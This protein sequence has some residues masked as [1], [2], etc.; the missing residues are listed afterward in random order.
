MLSRPQWIHIC[1]FP[2]VSGKHCFLE[3]IHHLWTLYIDQLWVS[4]LIFIYCW[5]VLCW[6]MRDS[7]LCRYS[8]KSSRVV[9]M[10]CLFSKLI[11]VGSPL[12]PMTYIDIGSWPYWQF[13]TWVSFHGVDLKSNQNVVGHSHN[14]S[15]LHQWAYLTRQVI[16]IAFKVHW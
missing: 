1:N 2:V 14:M 4:I 13:W 10:L 3:V 5:K 8:N 15:L 9:S 11:V 6:E 16:A 12:G 7:L